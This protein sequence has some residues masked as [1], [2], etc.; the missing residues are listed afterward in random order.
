RTETNCNAE[1][2]GSARRAFAS[3]TLQPREVGKSDRQRLRQ[4][5]CQRHGARPQ[6]GRKRVPKRG[7]GLQ[8]PGPPGIRAENLADAAGTSSPGSRDGSGSKRREVSRGELRT[9]QYL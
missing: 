6:K 3:R 8:R 9:E 7:Q 1:R 4:S 5:L 2:R